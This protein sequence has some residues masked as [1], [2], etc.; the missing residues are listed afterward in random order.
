MKVCRMCVCA[1]CVCLKEPFKRINANPD[2]AL[3]LEK[4]LIICCFHSV[5]CSLK[6][7]V[8][9]IILN[10]CWLD[11]CLVLELLGPDVRS[12]QLCFGNP[13]L[14]HMWVKQIL[15]QVKLNRFHLTVH[16]D[17]D[18]DCVFSCIV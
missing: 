6:L 10:T 3:F 8:C 16:A 13:G 11:M 5:C 14:S 12:W 15:T 4:Q 7:L 17:L 2:G 18:A 1:A 9:E